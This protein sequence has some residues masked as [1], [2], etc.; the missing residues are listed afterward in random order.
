MLVLLKKASGEYKLTD[1]EPEE[2]SF[3]DRPANRR[4]FIIVKRDGDTGGH[5]MANLKLTTDEKEK[6][7]KAMLEIKDRVENIDKTI[8]DAEEAE[9]IANSDRAGIETL[10]AALTESLQALVKKKD[11][12]PAP[13]PAEKQA[14][15]C[16]KCGWKGELPAT[17]K[18]PKCETVLK[19]DDKEKEAEKYAQEKRFKE[20]KDEL[21][22]VNETL[23]E[24]T[25]KEKPPADPPKAEGM[26]EVKKSLENITKRIADIEKA[27]PETVG[28]SQKPKE[29]DNTEKDV[30]GSD[31]MSLELAEEEEAKAAAKKK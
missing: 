6:F 14:V 26:D 2:I 19:G 20:V 4:P 30:W 10:V 23:A 21:A 3:V 11:P 25:K 22:R 28:S 1:I 17:G 24:L 27:A 9:D 16:P 29:G 5:T 12:E 18:C 8:T 31:D 7:A 15:T 13:A